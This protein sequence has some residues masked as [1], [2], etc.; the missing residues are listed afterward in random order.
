[1]SA[2]DNPYPSTFKT[3]FSFTDGKPL[4]AICTYPDKTITSG[5]IYTG[6]EVSE[7]HDTFNFF[8]NSSLKKVGEAS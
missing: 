1:M 3:T 6:D 5:Y 2:I 4:K 7:I 8:T